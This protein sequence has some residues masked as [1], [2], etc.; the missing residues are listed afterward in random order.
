MTFPIFTVPSLA[1]STLYG[2]VD[3]VARHQ[4][5]GERFFGPSLL[6]VL[7]R[8]RSR[9]S[10]GLKKRG[11]LEID[12]HANK[13]RNILDGRSSATERTR[14]RAPKDSRVLCLTTIQNAPGAVHTQEF[15]DIRI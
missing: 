15:A 10:I 1:P 14:K 9:H 12:A 4:G 13:K 2:D 7:Y 6:N 8:V 11:L 3:V 5:S